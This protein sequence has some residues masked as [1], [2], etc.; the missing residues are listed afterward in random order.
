MAGRLQ[1][2]YQPTNGTTR[3]IVK[4]A[5]ANLMVVNAKSSQVP[6]IMDIEHVV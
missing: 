1:L 2:A 4:L 6:R 3:P 5:E